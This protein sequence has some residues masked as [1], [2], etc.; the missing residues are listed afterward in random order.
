[1]DCGQGKCNNNVVYNDPATG[2]ASN[3]VGGDVATGQ[4]GGRDSR[5]SDG[6]DDAP[7]NTI[8]I[9]GVNYPIPGTPHPI[10]CWRKMLG[11][12]PMLVFIR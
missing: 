1:M 12:I 8:A 11:P 5:A 6:E 7:G 9:A 4:D 3:A 10:N 2:R